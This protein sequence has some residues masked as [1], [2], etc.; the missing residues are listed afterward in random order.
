MARPA[1]DPAAAQASAPAVPVTRNNADRF[2]L[3]FGPY[4]AP[5]F[6]VGYAVE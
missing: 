5:R 2:Q 6:R 4:Q 3:L 1:T